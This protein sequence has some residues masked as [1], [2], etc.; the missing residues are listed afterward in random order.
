ML[1][2]FRSDFVNGVILFKNIFLTITIEVLNISNCLRLKYP[3]IFEDFISL[4]FKW[5]GGR[6]TEYDGPSRNRLLNS[7]N[8]TDFRRRDFCGIAHYL[9]LPG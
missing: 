4:F 1:F 3:Q 5:K 8:P 2:L 9:V 6:R 7:R